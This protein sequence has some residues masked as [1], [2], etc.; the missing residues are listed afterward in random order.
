MATKKKVITIK[1][2]SCSDCRFFYDGYTETVCRRFPKVYI[3]ESD[4][5]G[6]SYPPHDPDEWCGEHK[7]ILAS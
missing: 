1:P 6:W 7:P 2:D 3:I 4:F 5:A